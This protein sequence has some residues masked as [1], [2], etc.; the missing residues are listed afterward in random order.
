MSFQQG[1]A[2]DVLYPPLILPLDGP[3]IGD[4][5]RS[6]GSS[7]KRCARLLL[8]MEVWIPSEVS[9]IGPVIN[10]TVRPIDESRCAVSNENAIEQPRMASTVATDYSRNQKGAIRYGFRRKHNR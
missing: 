7:I 6:Q 4:Q 5:R 1:N 9:F 2:A 10:R 8:E 3:R